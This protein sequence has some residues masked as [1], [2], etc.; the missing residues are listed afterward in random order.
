MKLVNLSLST[1]SPYMS[2]GTPALSQ[3]RV[4]FP[5]PIFTEPQLW[6]RRQASCWNKSWM[7]QCQ[8]PAGVMENEE[9]DS[10]IRKQGQI[11]GSGVTQQSGKDCCMEPPPSPRT[12]ASP[13]H[14]RSGPELPLHIQEPC[15][16][17]SSLLSATRQQYHWP[18]F[19]DGSREAQ[20]NQAPWS[21]LHGGHT[22]PHLWVP[23]LTLSLCDVSQ[24]LMKAVENSQKEKKVKAFLHFLLTV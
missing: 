3:L 13:L 12:E 6:V 18:H 21:Q 24:V 16:C 15:E 9:Y 11:L 19:T 14:A 20:W 5:Q 4:T 17:L 1:V 22:E 23:G 8:K 10:D 2:V 7:G